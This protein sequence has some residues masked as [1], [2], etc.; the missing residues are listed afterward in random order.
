[1]NN[2]KGPLSALEK[3]TYKKVTDPRPSSKKERSRAESNFISKIRTANGEFAT[4]TESI[5]KV[6]HTFYSQLFS[7]SRGYDILL[8]KF[9][10]LL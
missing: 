7:K 8:Q 6:F 4:D 10:G 2:E 3:S 9:P 1:M 5:L